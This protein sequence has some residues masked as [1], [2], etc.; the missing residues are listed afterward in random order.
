M[1][2]LQL[3]TDLGDFNST[4]FTVVDVVGVFHIEL[5]VCVKDCEMFVLRLL[6]CLL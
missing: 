5:C 3:V 4:D 1:A 6:H 2:L